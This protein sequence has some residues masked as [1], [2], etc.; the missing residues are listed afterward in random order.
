MLFNCEK[1]KFIPYAE[2]Y[3]REVRSSTT[4]NTNPQHRRKLF[5]DS[6]FIW[7]HHERLYEQRGM[8]GLVKEVQLLKIDKILSHAINNSLPYDLEKWSL[9][10]F[11]K[12]TKQLATK[13]IS[14]F[15]KAKYFIFALIG[16]NRYCFVYYKF[17]N[18]LHEN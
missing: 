5:L 4:N 3:Y 12:T 14:L 10:E 18:I 9:S 17:K 1:V 13:N 11:R 6:F 2:Y 15:K 7:E 16:P 8:M